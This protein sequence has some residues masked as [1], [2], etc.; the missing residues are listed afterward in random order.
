[1][2]FHVLGDCWGVSNYWPDSTGANDLL[3]F[4]QLWLYS[5]QSLEVSWETHG[6]E[7]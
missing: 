3:V 1:M 7:N 5:H 2:L 4:V 6:G